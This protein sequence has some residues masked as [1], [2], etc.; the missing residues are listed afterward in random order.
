MWSMT[1]KF[2]LYIFYKRNGFN[3]IHPTRMTCLP[4]ISWGWRDQGTAANPWTSGRPRF[5]MIESFVIALTAKITRS[6]PSNIDGT[7]S[8]ELLIYGRDLAVSTDL[9][10]DT[11]VANVFIF[12]L[13]DVL[14]AKRPAHYLYLHLSQ[15]ANY[16]LRDIL[17]TDCATSSNVRISTLV[18]STFPSTRE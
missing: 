10:Y 16:R 18:S 5:D 2:I 17:C 12:I 14:V 4:E 1:N 11:W 7:T 15:P 6:L 8:I 3:C 9:L 13:L